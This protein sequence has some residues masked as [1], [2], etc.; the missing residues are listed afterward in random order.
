MT[1][2]ATPYIY[3]ANVGTFCSTTKEKHIIPKFSALG[4]FNTNYIIFRNVETPLPTPPAT[5]S[6]KKF[7][8]KKL[9]KS[10]GK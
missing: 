4:Q 1:F 5:P 10:E 8:K 9:K 7:G 3:H 6:K 2:L